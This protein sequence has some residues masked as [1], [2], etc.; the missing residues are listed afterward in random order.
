MPGVVQSQIGWGIEQPDIVSG[1]P[2]FGIGT[3]GSL[4]YFPTKTILWFNAD[5]LI[6]VY[7]MGPAAIS[8]TTDSLKIFY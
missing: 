1:I 4:K 8:N 5:S 7:A 3:L 6:I 2:A